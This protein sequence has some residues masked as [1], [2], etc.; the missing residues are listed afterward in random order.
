MMSLESFA[1]EFNI[2]ALLLAKMW[3]M[4]HFDLFSMSLI[5]L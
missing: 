4:K 1:M 5:H 2:L 3:A